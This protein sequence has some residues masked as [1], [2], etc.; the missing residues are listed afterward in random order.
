MFKPFAI[1]RCKTERCWSVC[2]EHSESGR[3]YWLDAYLNEQYHDVEVE[4]NQ[5]IFYN[6]D[7]DD[8]ARKEFQEDG[9]NFEEACSEVICVLE[10]AKELFQD[11]DGGWY[12]KKKWKGEQTWTI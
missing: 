1:T 12:T 11:T 5:Y 2:L 10:K 7:T 3:K 6:T 9:D 4:W 8:M